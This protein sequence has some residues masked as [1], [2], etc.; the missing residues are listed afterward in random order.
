M[1]TVDSITQLVK[2]LARL[3][4]IGE[5]TATRFAFYILNAPKEEVQHLARSILQVKKRV[6]LCSV[7]FNITDRNPCSLCQNE[8]RRKETLCVVEDPAD[9]LAI[10]KTG[11]FKGTYHVLHG[12]IAPLDGITAEDLKIRE[13]MRRIKGEKIKEVIVA[14][15]PTVH[16]EATAL[17]L[18]EQIKP[19]GVR[20]TRIARGI[21]VGGDIEYTDEMTLQKALEGRREF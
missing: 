8:G 1:H 10:E 14:T 9:L 20:V 11:T 2:A 16:G 7:C 15:N 17:F 3:P 18:S 21:P 5:K 6:A 13:L 4:G 12:T 19:L